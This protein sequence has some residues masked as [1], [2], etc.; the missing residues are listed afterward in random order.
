[1]SSNAHNIH[2]ILCSDNH[3]LHFFTAQ[4]DQIIPKTDSCHLLY[5]GFMLENVIL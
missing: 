3:S 5:S 1:M 4:S 2:I